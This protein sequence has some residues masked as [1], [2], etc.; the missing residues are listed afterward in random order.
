[1]KYIDENS[2]II[3]QGDIILRKVDSIPSDAKKTNPKNDRYVLAEGE[4]T[5]HAHAIT[6]LDGC[7]VF[8]SE[9]GTLYVK[10]SKTTSV[11]HEEHHTQ[12]IEP[13]IYKVG[14]VR[15]ADPFS[16]VIRQVRD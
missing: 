4:T 11:V 16:E 10:A 14:R 13:G 1:M 12:T 5:L 9:D 7:E 15:E 8:S 3:Q 2:N 6:S